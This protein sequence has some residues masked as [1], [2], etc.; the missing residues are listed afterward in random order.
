MMQIGA[1]VVGARVTVATVLERDE[2]APVGRGG[3]VVAAVRGVDGGVSGDP[4]RVDAVEGVDSRGD[5]GEEIVRFADAEQMPRLVLRQLRGAPGDDLTEP[6]LFQCTAD[7]VAVEVLTIGLGRQQPA[8]SLPAQVFVLRTPHHTEQ[9][10]I[11]T[12]GALRGQFAVGHQAPLSPGLGP[13]YRGF[14]V[15]AGVQQS[16]QLV[17][18]EDDVCPELMLH[19]HADLGGEAMPVAVD[20]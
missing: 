11:R 5:R 8:A 1:G 17:E 4:A 7:T 16:G 20:R 12:M 18:R 19:R 10:L 2:G 3:D 6:L 14:L 9:R 15:P 13:L